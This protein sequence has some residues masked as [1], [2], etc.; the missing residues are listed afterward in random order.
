MLAKPK[1]CDKVQHRCGVCGCGGL[2]KLVTGGE[3]FYLYG[4][5]QQS[6]HRV[7][8]SRVPDPVTNMYVRRATSS[9]RKDPSLPS[10]TSARRGQVGVKKAPSC[11]AAAGGIASC[12]TRVVQAPVEP[13]RNYSDEELLDMIADA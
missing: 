12:R 10:S 6:A 13:V 4:C 3:R 5:L 9:V 2:L 7:R 11:R 8:I 1:K